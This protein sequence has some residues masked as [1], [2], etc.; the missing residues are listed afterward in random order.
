MIAGI[1]SFPTSA[2]K[3]PA[4]IEMRRLGHKLIISPRL[5]PAL[6]LCSAHGISPFCGSV[7]FWKTASRALLLFLLANIHLPPAHA[8]SPQ[9]QWE[10]IH[11]YPSGH[12]LSSAAW[13]P[14]GYVVVGWDREVLFSD[15]GQIWERIALTNVPKDLWVT[16][17]VCYYCGKYVI[18]G[19]PGSIFWSTNGHDWN[20]ADSGTNVWLNACTGGDGKYVIAGGNQTLLVSTNAQDWESHSA[21]VDFIDLVYGSN[22]WVALTGGADVYTSSDL[23]NWTNTKVNP[24]EGPVLNTVCFGQGR[25]I[26][27]GAWAPDQQHAFA[28]TVILYSADGVAWHF[29]TLDGLDAFGEVRDSVFANG[30]FVLLQ[31]ESFLRSTNGET[32][33]KITDFDAG[34]A[35][36]GIA[37]SSSGQF[38]AVGADGAMLTSDD[39]QVWSLISSNPRE[40]VQSV[41]YADGRFVAVGGSPSYI[42][43]PVGSAAVLT[44]TNGHDWQPS[45]T[46]LENQLSAVAYGNGRW[47]VCGDDGGIFTSSD[48]INWTNNSLPPTTHD[49][50]ELAYG[51]GRFIAFAISRDL[52]YHSTNGVD[53]MSAETPLASQVARARY[54]NG[55]FMAVGGNGAILFSDD[56][57]TWSGTNAP[58]TESLNTLAFGKG[59]YVAGGYFV[60]GYSL[61]GTNWTIQPAPIQV[62]DIQFIDGWFVA[63]GNG[64]GTL[65]SRDGVQWETID[66]PALN[67][68][69]LTALAY[70]NGALVAGGGLSLY[71]GT[72]NDS[73]V[74]RKRLRLL[75]PAQLEF[76]GTSGYEY[77]LE[78]STNL[79]DWS[80]ASDWSVG[81]NHYLLWDVNLFRGPWKFWRAAGR[82]P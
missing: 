72:L 51:N 67:E 39:A 35:L 71:R 49:L 82:T 24:F 47:V 31:E 59:R 12:W 37:G 10:H 69:E 58:T 73:E 79:T 52:V 44:S 26:A 32:W 76:Y 62:H 46:N 1:Y 18:I 4:K 45:L 54:I 19:Y 5:L 36:R 65:V 3:T 34:G 81:L 2:I 53:W 33:E 38:L 40:Y 13:G 56:G 55:R 61:D 23:V 77:R 43:G 20:T 48:A 50:H 66:D 16:D 27:S 25:F 9:M 21:P 17:K 64:Y 75:S 7:G 14:A 15:D 8:E 11:P 70:G 78:Q 28:A 80:P 6:V 42:G 30:Q 63:V 29:A 60:L 22:V 41:A 74:F 68:Y 57:L